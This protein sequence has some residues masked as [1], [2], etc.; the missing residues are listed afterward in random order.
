ME[1]NENINNVQMWKLKK[2]TQFQERK[3][4]WKK[5]NTSKNKKP[6]KNVKKIKAKK[7][8]KLKKTIYGIVKPIRL[9]KVIPCV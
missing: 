1:R 8:E 3:K 9:H 4:N 7:D 2:K 6:R 5:K